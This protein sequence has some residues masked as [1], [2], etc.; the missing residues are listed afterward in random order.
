VSRVDLVCVSCAGDVRNIVCLLAADDDDEDDDEMMSSLSDDV[1][2][3]G[4]QLTT[5][6]SPTRQVFD[7][8]RL[9]LSVC[10]SVCVWRCVSVWHWS[11]LCCH[12][13]L[14]LLL[15]NSQLCADI[16]AVP[17]ISQMRILFLKKIQYCVSRSLSN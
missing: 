2:V 17:C 3:V 1:I 5:S 7:C 8:S 16:A 13:L 6:P 11:G 12:H 9:G 10:L 14:L 15:D 4:R